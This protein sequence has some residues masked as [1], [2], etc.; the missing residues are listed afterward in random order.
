MRVT[1]QRRILV[2]AAVGA[3]AAAG[4]AFA[5]WTAS[6]S[7][8]GS[9]SVAESNGTIVLTGTVSEAM[10]PGGSS[11][12]SL[13]AANASDTDLQVQ[14]VKLVSVAVDEDHEDCVTADF[15]MADVLQDATV[16]AA[17][18]SRRCPRTGR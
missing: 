8:S 2:L 17:R 6:G 15:S 4:I 9:A 1:R 3:L 11:A 18:P 5:F 16:A 7:G 10:F 12:V 14:T 13:T